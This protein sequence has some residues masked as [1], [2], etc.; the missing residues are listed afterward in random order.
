MHGTGTL[1]NV[2]AVSAGSTHA[3]ALITGGTLECWGYDG[4]GELGN[5]STNSSGIPYPVPVNGVGGSGTLSAATQVSAGNQFTCAV[6]SGNAY[7]WGSDTDYTLGVTTIAA[8]YN[9]QQ[10]TSISGVSQVSAGRGA[11]AP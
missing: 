9:P 11:P 3:C 5:G 10:I 8:V 4:S 2:S 7:C 6:A 1:G